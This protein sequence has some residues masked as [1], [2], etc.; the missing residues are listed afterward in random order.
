VAASDLVFSFYHDSYG[1]LV[2][3]AHPAAGDLSPVQFPHRA[4]PFFCSKQ[5]SMVAYGGNVYVADQDGTVVR[6]VI[7]S[8]Q[9]C[10]AE[11]IIAEAP[12]ATAISSSEDT[13]GRR[14]GR[15]FLVPSAGE[16]LLVRHLR[17][18]RRRTVEVFR[19]DVERN[20]LKPMRSI[21]RRAL[22]L[23]VRCLSVDH[24]DRLPPIRSNCVYVVTGNGDGVWED[25]LGYGGREMKISACRAARP[26]SIVQMLMDCCVSLPDVK[27]QLHS[28]YRTSD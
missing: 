23:G 18:R 13:A 5:A 8:V 3:W 6:C 26:F 17:R 15:E 21:G 1:D 2:S 22:F 19:V 11:L 27:A 9:R 24:A 12:N 20:V 4:G 10:H 28:I 14:R 16:L 7:E 25:D